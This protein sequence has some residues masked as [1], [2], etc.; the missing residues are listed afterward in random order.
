[1]NFRRYYV[2][3]VIIFITQVVAEREPIF[4]DETCLILL[5][6]TLHQVKRLHPFAMLGYVFLPDHFHLLIKPFK[7]TMD[8]HT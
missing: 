3:D 2:A 1:M 7:D 4:R 8:Y 5:R 6:S